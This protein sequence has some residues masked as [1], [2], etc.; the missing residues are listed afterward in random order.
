MFDFFNFAHGG[1]CEEKNANIFVAKL[2]RMVKPK[3]V[4]FEVF[5]PKRKI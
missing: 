3:N 1:T 2:T 5:R 4:D